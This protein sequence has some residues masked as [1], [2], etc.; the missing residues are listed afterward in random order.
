MSG[1]VYIIRVK[2]EK[3][4]KIRSTIFA[5]NGIRLKLCALQH[6]RNDYK[7]KKNLLDCVPVKNIRLKTSGKI[8]ICER[9]GVLNMFMKSVFNIPE[10]TVTELDEK[11]AAV[12]QLIDGKRS[13]YE[14]ADGLKNRYGEDC[15]PLYE[16][17]ALF[18]KTLSKSGFIV[19]KK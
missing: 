17:L 14:I 4:E 12:W 9:R 13:V 6:E 7:M 8:I 2:K 1:R 19:W 15:E 3:S 11:S 5:R 16:R 18:L 10:R